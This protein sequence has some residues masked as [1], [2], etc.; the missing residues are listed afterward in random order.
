MSSTNGTHGAHA[1]ARGS[2]TSGH[3]FSLRLGA[4]RE[5]FLR[6]GVG[7]G[8]MIGQGLTQR[9]KAAKARICICLA[10]WRERF[11]PGVTHSSTR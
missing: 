3:A 4:L 2:P 5:V 10:P 11:H 7:I 8:A 6:R 1:T 9:R